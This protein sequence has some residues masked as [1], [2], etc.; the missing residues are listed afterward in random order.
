MKQVEGSVCSILLVTRFLFIIAV[1]FLLGCS[2]KRQVKSDAG[3]AERRLPGVDSLLLINEI[4]HNFSSVSEEDTF[5]IYVAGSSITKGEF[6]FQIITSKNKV[7]YDESLET[8]WLLDFDADGDTTE[9]EKENYIRRR[10]EDFFDEDNFMKPAISASDSYEADYSDKL[11]WD[12]IKSD[13]TSIGFYYLV[14]KEDGRRIAYSKRSKN[15]VL[16]Y[17]CC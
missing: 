3:G 17:N 8:T 4:T 10:I 6:H 14:G 15:V 9:N 7:I 16:Y 5:R 11:I 12:E 1:Y 13:S 2:G